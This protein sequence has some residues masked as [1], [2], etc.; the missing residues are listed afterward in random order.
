MRSQ[1]PNP[2]I[3]VAFSSLDK[4]SVS[5][6]LDDLKRHQINFFE[7]QRDIPPGADMLAAVRGAIE[8]CTHVV[9]Y[10]SP[11]S[12]NSA[13]VWLETG[14]GYGHR[15]PLIF[16]LDHPSLKLPLPFSHLRHVVN[17]QEFD[18]FVASLSQGRE[19]RR[20]MSPVEEF[21]KDKLYYY[22]D[23]WASAVR[24]WGSE[25]VYFGRG[26]VG[27]EYTH[28]VFE[29]PPELVA[30]K[31][32]VLESKKMEAASRGR[33]FFNGPNVRLASFR[34]SPIDESSA[35]ET[36]YLTLHLG[37]IGWY[38]YEGLNEAFREQLGNS[39]PV[40]SYQYFVGIRELVRDGDVSRSKLSNIL[41]NAVTIVTSDGYALYGERSGRVTFPHSL[42][43]AVAE[44]VNRYLD[45]TDESG[46]LINSANSE[47]SGGA[48]RI[49]E[50]YIPIGIPNPFAAVR[51][52]VSSE[53]S[54]SLY[55]STPADAMKVTGLAFGLDIFHPS[56]LFCLFASASLDE[57]LTWRAE[58]PGSESYELSLK[59]TPASLENPDTQSVLHSGRWV[60]AGKASLIRALELVSAIRRRNHCSFDEAFQ[61]LAGGY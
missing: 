41:D 18:G 16:Y 3:M 47:T 17:R 13:W 9:I 55:D 12:I 1:A 31:E 37:P 53:I 11:A 4:D 57:I 52:G 14:M 34:V 26:R 44:N 21:A 24:L 40:E 43:S 6:L 38:D 49:G 46:S 2:Y 39:P 22:G 29:T 60:E 28:D 8:L 61:R 20:R 23:G 48:D 10:A 7:F 50:D 30:S 15:K 32:R 42:T 27:V 51:R 36:P 35:P 54:P 19:V 33:V 45:D 56:L 59:S 5:G 25:D 58:N